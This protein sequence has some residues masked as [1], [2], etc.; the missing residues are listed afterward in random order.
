MK[1]TYI[2]PVTEIS[3][4]FYEGSILQG[5]MHGTIDGG[6]PFGGGGGEGGPGIPADAKK[7]DLWADDEEE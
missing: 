5:T 3:P 7:F 6:D 1:K 4:L 2:I